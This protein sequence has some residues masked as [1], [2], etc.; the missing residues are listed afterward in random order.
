GE[1]EQG[2]RRYGERLE[3]FADAA[4]GTTEKSHLQ[5]LVGQVLAETRHALAE[6]RNLETRIDSSSKEIASLRTNLDHV[7]REALTDALTGIAN[8]KLFDF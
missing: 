3:R 6:V 4:E 2:T 1:A 7:R 5:N 8:R